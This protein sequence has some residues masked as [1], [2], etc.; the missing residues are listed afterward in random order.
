MQG[1]QNIE[2]KCSFAL[3]LINAIAKKQMHDSVITSK[4]NASKEWNCIIS[5]F[6][7]SFNVSF[8]FV[9]SCFMCICI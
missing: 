5:M 2:K 3:K 7:T 4:E 6:L 1:A 8:V 9:Y